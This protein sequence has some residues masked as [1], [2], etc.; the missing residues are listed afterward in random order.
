MIDSEPMRLTNL[1]IDHPCKFI[2][3]S[4]IMLVICAMIAQGAGFFEMDIQNNRE[5]LIWDD[6]RVIA[7]D[8]L[9]VA[10]EYFLTYSSGEV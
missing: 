5:Y 2:I 7:W 3:S 8:K 9:T 6:K 10:E 1:Y 4:F